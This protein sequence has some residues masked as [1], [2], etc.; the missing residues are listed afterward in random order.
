MNFVFTVCDN[1][2]DKSC[3]SLGPSQPM[4]LW[5]LGVPDPAAV[6]GTDAEKHL[7]F[8]TPIE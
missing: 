1:A 7:D 8:R 2:A 6:E 4:T 5:P 3:P